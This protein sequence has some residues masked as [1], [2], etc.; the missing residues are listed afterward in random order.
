[1]IV[2]FLP[3][4]TVG[5]YVVAVSSARLLTVVQSG[6]SSVLFPSVAAGRSARVAAVV[7][8][9]FRIATLLFSGLALG[10]GLVGPKLLMLA[11]GPRFADCI[12]PFCILLV[13]MVMENGAR[14]LYQIYSG[15][16]RPGIVSFFELGAVSISLGLM[17]LLVPPFGTVG[18]AGAVLGASCLRLALAAG[19]LRLVLGDRHRPRLLPG[20]RDL[21]AVRAGLT[22]VRQPDALDN[23]VLGTGA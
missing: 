14:I 19:A 7:A 2:A 6:I 16:G 12:A 4:R 1:M 21:R 20:L 15:S 17:L 23:A 13:A 5:T 8:D 18:A 9:T 22:R 11:Y 3:P 10:L